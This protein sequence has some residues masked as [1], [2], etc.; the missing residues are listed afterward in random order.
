MCVCSTYYVIISHQFS[1]FF[2]L[3]S[4]VQSSGYDNL[5]KGPVQTFP[6]DTFLFRFTNNDGDFGLGKKKLARKDTLTV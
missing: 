1:V 5:L 3:S 6:T 4:C 2:F